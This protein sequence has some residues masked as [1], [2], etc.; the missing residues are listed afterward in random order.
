MNL[1]HIYIMVQRMCHVGILKGRCWWIHEPNQTLPWYI[2]Y[3]CMCMCMF[4]GVTFHFKQKGQIHLIP[5]CREFF[6]LFFKVKGW[7]NGRDT[8]ML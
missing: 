2:I 8:V 7:D 5:N 1:S 6:L 4:S 3:L